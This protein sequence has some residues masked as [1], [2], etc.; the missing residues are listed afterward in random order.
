MMTAPPALDDDPAQI[1]FLR[2][3]L[4]WLGAAAITFSVV[5]SSTLVLF[6]DT[7]KGEIGIALA[8]FCVLLI[9]VRSRMYQQPISQSV[10]TLCGG[11]LLLN[12]AIT[13]IDPYYLEITLPLL[14]VAIALPYLRG[15]SLRRL[16]VGCWCVAM[17]VIFCVEQQQYT[18]THS[19]SPLWFD[20]VLSVFGNSVLLGTIL[21]L[22]WHFVQTTRTILAAAHEREARFQTLSELTSDYAYKVTIAPDGENRVIWHG[23]AITQVLGY[24]VEQ[25]ETLPQGFLSIIH[26]DDYPLALQRRVRVLNN[27]SDVAEL[28]IVHGSGAIRWL[29]LYTHPEWSVAE[30]R[31]V[32]AVGAMQD[33]TEQKDYQQQIEQLAFYD[34]LTGLA[35]RRLLQ[36]R[37]TAAL[38]AAAQRNAPL[39]VLYFDLDRFKSV[40]DTLGHDVGDALLVQIAERLRGRAKPDDLLARLGGDEFALILFDTDEVQAVSAAQCITAQLEADFVVAG[41]TLH[42][43]QSIGIAC[44]PHDGD[45]I[46]TLLRHADIAMYHAKLHRSQ[47][48]RY[49]PALDRARQTQL[50]LEA[51]LRQAIQHNELTLYYQPIYD[52]QAQQIAR[53]EALARWQHPARGLLLPDAFIPLAEECGLDPCA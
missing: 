46:D 9:I 27:Q 16:V 8:V 3:L 45:S 29:R 6:H 39:A 43:R 18:H 13:L 14:I 48:Q 37:M 12:L 31:V 24:T 51:E 1:I 10:T 25:L 44:F 41:H 47:Y 20:I 34:A 33:I 28:R 30:Q 23:G 21:V 50:L 15:R 4:T 42:I 52:M 5:L 35:N 19:A 53:V 49:T 40:N 11:L 17:L 32:S 22:L 7:R 36:T 26:P 38:A 2:R